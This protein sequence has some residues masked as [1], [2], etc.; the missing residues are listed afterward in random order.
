MPT[1]ATL[2]QGQTQVFQASGGTGVYTWAATGGVVN[3]QTGSSVT[4]T[5]GNQN[6][7]FSVVVTSG[8]AVAA[9][10]VHIRGLDIRALASTRLGVGETLLFEITN[11]GE[12]TPPFS[13]FSTN[14]SVATIVPVEGGTRGQLTAR[15]VGVTEVYARDAVGIDS[16][17]IEVIVGNTVE[18]P[19]VIGEAGKPAVA[20][21]NANTSFGAEITSLQM[22]IRFDPSILQAR[23][24]KVTYRSAHFSLGTNFDNTLGSATLL[25]TSLT[26]EKIATGSGPILDLLFDVDPGATVG[27]TRTLS[28]ENV[29]MVP[30][31]GSPVP[32]TP[33]DGVFE[34][35]PACLV[36]DGDVNQDGVVSVIDLQMAIN[37]Y[38][39]RY[40]PNSEEFAA[41]DMSPAPGGDGD[42]NVVDVLKILNKILGKPTLLQAELDSEQ[43]FASTQAQAAPPVQLMVPGNISANA[44]QSL[45]VPVYMNNT[46]PVGGVDITLV[47]TQAAGIVSTAPTV[48]SPRGSQLSLRWNGDNA[49]YLQII[50]HSPDTVRSIPAGSGTLFLINMGVVPQAVSSRLVVNEAAVSD[51][52]GAPISFTVM[53]VPRVYLPLITRNQTQ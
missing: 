48:T 27:I 18:I 40:T 33:R 36:H 30:L 6:G 44:G 9:A 43:L 38:L 19:R 52:N 1:S 21:I 23:Q 28:F 32:V 47:Y 42:V 29:E 37:I 5:A 7:D 53:E 14:T 46:V 45:I 3:P 24:A 13:W 34:V 11:P 22:T 12:N 17:R 4:F 49:G 25:M 8:E 31:F 50:L 41:A 2:K 39:L 26:G 16:N 10:A 51:V 20:H 15:A 35:C